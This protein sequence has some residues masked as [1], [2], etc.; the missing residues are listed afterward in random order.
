MEI[1]YIRPKSLFPLNLP[2]NKI[3]GSICVGINAIYGEDELNTML[4]NFHSDSVPFIISSA[5][6]FVDG[7][8]DEAKH[9]FFP[10][11]ITEPHKDTNKDLDAAKKFK[12][13][14]YV[15]ESIFNEWI[16]GKISEADIIE[17]FKDKYK[18][19]D[20]LLFPKDIKPSFNLTV[21]D[22]P[23]NQ[24]NRLSSS[25]ENFYYSK[26]RYFGNAGQFFLIKFFDNEFK[27]KIISALKFIEDRGFGGDIS[28]GDGQFEVIDG[29]KSIKIID[30]PDGADTLATLSRYSPENDFNSFDKGRVWYEL[31][32]VQGKCGDG[33]MKKTLLMFKEGSTFPISDQGVYGQIS[34][35]R[36]N[37]KRT[38]EYGVAFP[39]KVKIRTNKE[40]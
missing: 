19:K 1:V 22:L 39:I 17:V 37:P 27:P 3:F 16:N 23:H 2:S 35:V 5:F 6:P 26:G 13:V 7:I 4:D 28:S 31:S 18:I 15:E 21:G 25:S 33:V 20:K 36:P 12:K 30:E 34:E 14:E 11:L 8:K 9:H 32:K 40:G 24:I 10:K 38:V 29:I